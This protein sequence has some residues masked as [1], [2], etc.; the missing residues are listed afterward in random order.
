MNRA[1]VDGVRGP[2]PPLGAALTRDHLTVRHTVAVPGISTK[3]SVLRRALSFAGPGYMVAVGYVDPGNWATSLAGGSNFGYSLLS[4]ILLSNAMAMLLQAAA[5]RLGVASGL[6]L[7]QSCR[8]H[9]PPGVNFVL[10]IGCEIAV[11]ACNLAELLGMA[12]GLGLLFHVPLVIGVCIAALDVILILLLQR[13]GVRYLE[14]VI[15]GLVAV[16]GAC[17]AAQL[18]W[19]HPP[20][21]AVASG[22][23]P[24]AQIAARPEML[25]LAVGMV[26]ATVMPHNLYLHSSIVQTRK[27]DRC[28]AGIRQA[29]R[30]A[31]LDSNLA[32][33]MAL[34]VNA[35]ILVLA[36]GA[37]NHTGQLPALEFADAYRLLSPLLG[38]AAASTL[39]GV[40]LLA[41]GLSSSITGTLAGQIVM[42]G[43]LD[44]R[45]SRAKRAL[46]TRCFAIL[47]A[48][49]V[50]AWLGTA[51]TGT[52]MIL[53]QVILG[54]QL[55]FAVVPLLWFTTRRK[56]L[57]VHA[58]RPITGLLLWSIAI[59][60]VVINVWVIYRLT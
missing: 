2:P 39:F 31:T 23:L 6:D 15:I 13:K 36:A 11:I 37:F 41:A 52:L 48:V 16:I 7:A 43:F 42:E 5:V 57:G 26:G 8:A 59:V 28:E 19:L 20:L 51:K 34:F 35:A 21:G 29:I 53:S 4:V 27:H 1:V 44:I 46:M 10:W 25:Y 33:A 30:Y 50:T 56:H 32:L 14:A 24:T 45:V 38:V 22:F 18:W 49:A 55:P 12:C 54:L 9:F 3:S 17:F 40:G 58:F 47:P 60:L